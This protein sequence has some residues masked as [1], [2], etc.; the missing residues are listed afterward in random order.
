[1]VSVPIEVRALSLNCYEVDYSLYF[2]QCSFLQSTRQ[3]QTV[4]N[5]CS[6]DVPAT[7]RRL[8]DFIC[9]PWLDICMFLP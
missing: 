6:G 4:L 5:G 7:A 1:M 9:V 2:P 3:S 8:A